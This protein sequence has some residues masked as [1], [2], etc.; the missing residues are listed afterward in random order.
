SCRQASHSP[1]TPT[2]RHSPLQQWISAFAQ[3]SPNSQNQGISILTPK[4]IPR[5]SVT[6]VSKVLFDS[7]KEAL[8]GAGL[9]STYNFGI[10][11][12]IHNLLLAGQYCPLTLFTNTNTE[13]LHREGHLLKRSK[14]NINGVSY[15]L[16]NLS[17]FDNELDMDQLSWQEAYQRYLTWIK[18]IGDTNSLE[19]WTNHFTTLSKDEAVRKNFHAIIEFDMETCQNYTLR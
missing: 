18:D 1:P 7:L 15:H 11:S 12:F 13:H 8:G 9:D 16:L 5:P 14:I 6:A 3:L 10:H 4:S 17:Q 2:N 19:C